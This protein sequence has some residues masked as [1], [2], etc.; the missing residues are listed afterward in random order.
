MT[1]RKNGFRRRDFLQVS[2]AS[3]ALAAFTIVPRYVLGGAGLLPPSEKL[4]IACIGVGNRG[5]TVI[6]QLEAH[7][8][9]AICDVDGKYLGEAAERYQ[10]AR[11]YNDFRKLIDWEE[12]NIDAVA[13][14]STDHTHALASMAALRAGKHVYCEKP[15]THSVYEARAMAEAIRDSGLSHAD[16]ERSALGP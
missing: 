11:K 1:T 4:N 10:S 7:N 6:R 5:W 15:L 13:V 2:T 14:C 8:I 9:V 3:A 16:G 12:N